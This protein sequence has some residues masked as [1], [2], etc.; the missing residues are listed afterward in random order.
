MKK[1]IDDNIKNMES[2]VDKSQKFKIMLVR[3]SELKQ[4]TSFLKKKTKFLNDC[5]RNQWPM[6]YILILLKETRRAIA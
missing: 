4:K 6:S 1:T 3:N 2:L 5:L